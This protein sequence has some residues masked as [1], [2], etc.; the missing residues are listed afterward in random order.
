MS[1]VDTVAMDAEEARRL[2]EYEARIAA[3]ILTFVDVGDALTGV[4][5]E[6]L[7]RAEYGT[8]EEYCRERWGFSD[9]R[10][11]Q[12]VGAAQTVTM[13]TDQGLPAPV[14][15]RQAREL[16]RIPENQRAD[17]WR[18]T[19]ERTDGKPT[20]AAIRETWQPTAPEP[21]HGQGDVVD[22]EI[23][24]EEPEGEEWVSAQDALAHLHAEPEPPAAAPPKPAPPAPMT[25]EER[26]RMTRL[27][28][29]QEA[30]NAW[31][32]AVDGL[33]AALSYAKTYDPPDD[34]PDNYVSPWEFLRRA[35]AITDIAEN[36]SGEQ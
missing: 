5:D 25:D 16:S 31:G 10:A 20:A 7:Y 12:L 15:E 14:S 3:G 19:H 28:A 4:R 27:A 24:D 13:V 6:R 30:L 9:S 17:V 26:E 18:E 29:H 23:V 1:E 32:Q 22:A 35:R 34:L 11:R 21:S 2:D 33:T 36:W 8:F